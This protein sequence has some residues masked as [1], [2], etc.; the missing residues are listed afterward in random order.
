MRITIKQIAEKCNV[1]R[2]TVDKVINGRPGVNKNTKEKVL[3]II[4]EL[5]YKPNFIGKALVK[6]QKPIKIGIILSPAHN[7]FIQDMIIGIKRGEDE[8]SSFGIEVIT[9]CMEE[10]SEDEQ[11][12]IL[13]EFESIMV[14]AIAIFPIDTKKIKRKLSDL[15]KKIT[16][17]TFNSYISIKNEFCFIGQDHYKGG[18]TA[19]DLM[20]KLLPNKGKILV[21]ISSYNLSCHTDRLLGFKDYIKENNVDFEIVKIE[22]NYDKIDKAYQI[23]NS[24][25]KHNNINGIYLTGSGIGGIKKAL[26]ENNKKINIICHDLLYETIDMLKEGMIGFAIS[27]SPENQGYLIVK[28]LFEHL[29]KNQT[30]KNKKL[31]VPII[32]H[33]KESID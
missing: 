17:L 3:K 22:E 1:S 2:G 25:I 11:L 14:D 8:F 32:I 33:T 12:K 31:F 10:I 16:I 5:N 13:N 15:T 9:K 30:P 29:V 6:I 7:P 4:E 27:Q 20:H 23:S 18:R 28:T 26:I 19:A 24:A 21:I